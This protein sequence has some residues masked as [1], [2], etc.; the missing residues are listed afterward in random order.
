MRVVPNG[1]TLRVDWTA[2]ERPAIFNLI[3]R[4]GDV[5]EE[6]MR[7]TFNLGVGLIVVADRKGVDVVVNSLKRKQEKPI[8]LGEIV[9]KQ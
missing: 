6:D 7:R 5:P 2:W 8:I 3:K 1:L 9:H 4:V